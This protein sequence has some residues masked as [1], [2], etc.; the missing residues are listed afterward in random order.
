MKLGA[1]AI[2]DAL[3]FKEIWKRED[4]DIVLA[5]LR[6]LRDTFV[7]DIARAQRAFP[8]MAGGPAF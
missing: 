8:A 2:L 1:V 6:N 5:K 3:G 7:G 4:P